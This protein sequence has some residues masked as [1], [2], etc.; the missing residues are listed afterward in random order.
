MTLPEPPQSSNPTPLPQVM[1]N[2]TISRR[3]TPS[4]R[5]ST[6][7]ESRI[8]STYE[9]PDR[10]DPSHRG[11]ST[12]TGTQAQQ[13]LT[14]LLHLPQNHQFDPKL[15]LQ[16]L[17]HKSYRFN[18]LPK[19]PNLTPTPTPA[20]SETFYSAHNARLSFIGRRAIS[21]YLTM[22]LHASLAIKGST[23][24][25]QGVGLLQPGEDLATKVSNLMHLNNVGRTVGVKWGIDKVV[26]WDGNHVSLASSYT[27]SHR[28]FLR[29]ISSYI[30]SPALILLYQ[31]FPDLSHIHHLPFV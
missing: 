15:S 9:R 1:L 7:R 11:T 10:N 13:Y 17:T 12:L 22:F 30:A 27:I 29:C 23:T 31:S 6:P 20:E 19:N 26:R 18:Y 4:S 5:S 21:S 8:P 3:N 28:H 16:M 14:E 2:D 25:V 24:R